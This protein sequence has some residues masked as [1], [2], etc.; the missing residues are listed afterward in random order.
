MRK[1]NP[2]LGSRKDLKK[3]STVPQVIATEVLPG[4]RICNSWGLAL[5]DG[6]SWDKTKRYSQWIIPLS[7]YLQVTSYWPKK[8]LQIEISVVINRKR[9]ELAKQEDDV[10]TV[11]RKDTRSAVCV[12]VQVESPGSPVSSSLPPVSSA[13]TSLRSVVLFLSCRHTTLCL[14]FRYP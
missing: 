8:K 1:K 11:G 9:T 13:L 6:G 3:P 14:L 2:V 4:G 12:R 7:T 5:R 10:M